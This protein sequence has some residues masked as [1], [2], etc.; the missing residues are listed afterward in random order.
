MATHSTFFYEN[1]ENVQSRVGYSTGRHYFEFA[2]SGKVTIGITTRDF[3][4]NADEAIGADGEIYISYGYASNGNYARPFNRWKT[5]AARRFH[6]NDVIGMY[7]DLDSA[8]IVFYRSGKQQRKKLKIHQK[9][10][11]IKW[12]VTATLFAIGSVVVLLRS[13][14]LPPKTG[15][16]ESPDAENSE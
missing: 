8:E 7:L 4:F 10:Q 1:W 14:N 11:G 6:K 13:S 16:I 15:Q 5:S 12:F 2:V 3:K 9:Y